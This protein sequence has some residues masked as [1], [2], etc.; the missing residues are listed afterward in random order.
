M[1]HA[2]VYQITHRESGK[3]YIGSSVELARRWNA[4]RFHLRPPR[5]MERTI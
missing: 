3:F 2:G 1:T 5:P 4:H